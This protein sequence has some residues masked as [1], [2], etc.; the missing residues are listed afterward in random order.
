MK[1]ILTL[2]LLSSVL[3][4]LCRADEL[5][6]YYQPMVCHTDSCVTVNMADSTISQALEI[7][8]SLPKMTER[9]GKS[10]HR[11]SILFPLTQG[12]KTL[13]IRISPGTEAYN[14]S[15]EKQY[16][17]IEVLMNQKDSSR[18]LFDKKIYKGVSFG[19]G[20]NSISVEWNNDGR[21]TLYAGE[22][23]LAEVGEFDIHNDSID[24]S[25]P[26]GILNHG[27]LN[28][29]D[30]IYAWTPDPAKGLHTGIDVAHLYK[31]LSEKDIAAPEGIW[32]YLDRDTD[33]R[34]GRLGGNYL[35]GIRKADNG[36]DF[37]IIYLGGAKVF[38]DKWQPGMLKGKLIP[39]LFEGHYDLVWYDGKM[40]R[41]DS[42]IS[43]SVEQGV[44]LTLN[45]PLYRSKLR[46]SKVIADN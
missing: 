45:F 15:M 35:I 6:R 30:L 32:K 5:R 40:Q 28:I 46:F 9:E 34:Y 44:I 36:K 39:T 22:R 23:T 2:L 18:T 33:E 20:A 38:S 43:A 1:R 17:S 13:E 31:Q 27:T 11:Y 25:R 14:H 8:A 10:E 26:I 12:D 21:F 3:I 37:D 4:N 7:R 41:M 19:R 29:I 42:D 16:I 24:L